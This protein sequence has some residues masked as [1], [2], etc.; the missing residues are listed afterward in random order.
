MSLVD[1]DRF[2]PPSD[3]PLIAY[4][5]G[6]FLFPVVINYPEE[7]FGGFLAATDYR[8]PVISEEIEAHGW[9]IWPPHPLWRTNFFSRSRTFFRSLIASGVYLSFRRS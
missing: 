3:R 5:K 8:D 2:A 1:T 7:K 4:Y 9:A 6:E